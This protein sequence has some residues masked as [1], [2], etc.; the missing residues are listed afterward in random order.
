MA[1]VME[2]TTPLGADVL[3]FHA[4]HARE[5]LSRVSEYQLDLLSLK[6]DIN[7]D[8]ILGKNV[9]VKLAL[10][11]GGTRYYNGYVTRFSQGGMHGRYRRYSATVHPWLWFLSRTAD[12]RI[13]QEMTVPK[14]VEKIF[15]EHPTAAHKNSLTGSYPTW[16]YCVQYR[17]T[18]LNF[19]CRLL[20]QEGI[21]FYFTHVDG[22]HTLV[23][24]DS[25]SAHAPFQGQG[26]AVHRS[27]C[28][29]PRRH[30]AHQL[31]EPDARDPAGPLRARRLRFRAAERG[32]A[33]EEG[34]SSRSY[35]PS[36]YEMYDYPGEYLM[37][38]EGEATASV[39][40][41]EFG[42]QFETAQ[43]TANV[44]AIS[45]GSLF[46]LAKARAPIRTASTWWCRRP[47]TWS[48]ATTR[49]CRSGAAP[50]T[51][52]ASWRCRASSSSGRAGSRPSR[53]SRVRRPRS[54]SDPPARRSTPTSTAG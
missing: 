13:F 3:L 50:T 28:G 38:A 5:E 49:R 37:K 43:A 54:S 14:I 40:I 11:S 47:T 36:T 35:T 8:Q 12:C 53:R 48:S 17:E 30:R 15:S 18:D 34:R 31:V 1:R 16:T 6:H 4:M 45:V 24:A 33:G 19:V 9:T 41:D 52:A 22:K 39:R 20:E 29:G 2:I 25:Y 10:Q 27:R 44:R 32:A 26:G 7:L 42:A 51:A 23:M 21:Y 46:T